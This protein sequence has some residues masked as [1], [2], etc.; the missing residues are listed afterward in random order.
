ML[1]PAAYARMDA[2][3]REHNLELI[4]SPTAYRSCH[5]LPEYYHLIAAQTAKSVWMQV[6]GDPDFAAIH[7]QL[8]V[9][10]S[11]PVIV[12]DYVK[13]QKHYWKE[14]C[15]IPHANEQSEVERVVRRFLELQSEAFNEGLVFREFLPIRRI[16]MHAKSGMPLSLEF[17]V[18]VLDST[19]VTT[20]RYWAEGL[21]DVEPPPLAIFANV[22]S[23]IPSRFFAL[24]IA[25]LEDRRWVIMEIGDGQVSGLNDTIPPADFYSALAARLLNPLPGR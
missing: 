2:A 23:R 7:A 11:A 5:Y 19:P 18:F 16:G 4:T 3:L 13:S 22:L 25:Q 8:K 17:R 1:K 15:F 20:S 24:D 21:Y 14:A 9:F 12:K 10:G 6:S